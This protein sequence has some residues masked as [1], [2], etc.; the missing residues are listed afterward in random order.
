MVGN[1]ESECP[2]ACAWPF[3]KSNHGPQGVTLQPP[4]GNIGADSMVVHFASG[5]AGA[6]TNPF[7]TG[8]FQLGTKNDHELVEAATACPN[9][10]G[11]GALPGYTGKVRVDPANGGAFNTHG[12]KGMQFLVPA[13]WN[14]RTSS[15]W[16]PM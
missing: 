13:I 8:F 2:G 3:H 12:Y 11:S 7:K 16:T 5:L 6:V 1:P 4:N 9:I 15:C 10:F 14:P